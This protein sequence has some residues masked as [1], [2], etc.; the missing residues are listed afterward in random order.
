MNTL[1]TLLFMAAMGV[2]MAATGKK[3][4]RKRLHQD[5][6]W[7]PRWARRLFYC[8]T[9]MELM[10]LL[11]GVLMFLLALVFYRMPLDWEQMNGFCKRG[12]PLQNPAEMSFLVAILGI[13]PGLISCAIK[14]E[15]W[16]IGSAILVVFLAWQ[17]QL[18]F[19]FWLVD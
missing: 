16:R 12:A 11:V 19:V 3:I 5:E 10:A 2:V 14:P 8:F 1:A 18:R 6:A 13:V 17:F 9:M 15:V 4:E 7:K